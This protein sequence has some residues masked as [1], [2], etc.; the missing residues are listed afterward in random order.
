MFTHDIVYLVIIAA[1]S[2]AAWFER[3]KI[4]AEAIKVVADVKDDAE[5]AIAKSVAES[6]AEI[7]KVKAEVVADEKNIRAKV[8]G[9][10]TLILNDIRNDEALLTTHAYQIVNRVREE[11]KKI[12]NVV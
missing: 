8:D 5:K 9:E 6:E 10:I 12:L 11:L 7:A 3:K 1:G 2:A 4:K